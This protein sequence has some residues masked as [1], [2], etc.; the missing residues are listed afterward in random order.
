[1]EF[2]KLPLVLEVELQE[3]TLVEKNKLAIDKDP[4]LK[5][6]QVEMK[7]PKLIIENVL[8][9]VEDFNFPINSLTFGMEEN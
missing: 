3:P 7:Y 1:M 6:K 4:S 5:E 2:D 8:V 9:G